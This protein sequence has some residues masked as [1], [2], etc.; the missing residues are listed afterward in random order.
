MGGDDNDDGDD[1]TT[2][3]ATTDDQ[4]NDAMTTRGSNGD[5]GDW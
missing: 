4:G 1:L 2:R 5:H 3:D